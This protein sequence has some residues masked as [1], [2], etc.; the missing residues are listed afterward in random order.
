MKRMNN[1][2]PGKEGDHPNLAPYSKQVPVTVEKPIDWNEDLSP[3]KPNPH[4]VLRSLRQEDH[5]LKNVSEKEERKVE[6][7][8]AQIEMLKMSEVTAPGKLMAS[9]KHH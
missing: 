5:S 7:I 1:G 4:S 3:K 6:G 8:Q 2:G 9:H